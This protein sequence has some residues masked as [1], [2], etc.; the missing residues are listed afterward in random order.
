MSM[1]VVTARVGGVVDRLLSK[2]RR[3]YG[4][5]STRASA[6]A[7]RVRWNRHLS[8]LVSAVSGGVGGVWQLLLR[9]D[10]VFLRSPEMLAAHPQTLKP[11]WASR[12]VLALA[13]LDLTSRA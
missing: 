9:D 6:T 10:I 4:T 12:S 7:A 13:R 8:A 2:P 3:P 5:P 1:I 11:Y